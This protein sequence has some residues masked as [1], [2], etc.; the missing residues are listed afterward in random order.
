MVFFYKKKRVKI[1]VI[2][3]KIVILQANYS[4]YFVFIQRVCKK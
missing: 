4:A 2:Q 1:C 3:K